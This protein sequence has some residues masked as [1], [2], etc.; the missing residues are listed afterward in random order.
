MKLRMASFY[1]SGTNLFNITNYPGLEPEVSDNPMSIIGGSRDISSYPST[2]E[3]TI[4]VRFG[5]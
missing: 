5:L 3:F 1:I 4:G 2:R